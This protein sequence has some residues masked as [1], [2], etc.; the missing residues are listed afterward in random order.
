MKSGKDKS[1][2]R[3]KGLAISLRE[4]AQMLGCSKPTAREKLS[5]E[6]I[7]PVRYGKGI[8]AKLWYS[9][10]EVERIISGLGIA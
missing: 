6:S 4:I 7:E 1:G 3:G 5:C 8:N 2:R 10:R 9:R